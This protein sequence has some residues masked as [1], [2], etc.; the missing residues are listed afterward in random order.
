MKKLQLIILLSFLSLASYAQVTANF[1]AS[2]TTGCLPDATIVF[3]NQST[4][5]EPIAFYNWDINGIASGTDENLTYTFTQSGLF[6][7]HLSV[8]DVSGN[9]DTYSIIIN[10]TESP[11]VTLTSTPTPLSCTNTAVILEANPS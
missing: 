1:M 9:S 4:S 6:D 7:I 11:V 8:T 10:I 5:V 2:A 3:T